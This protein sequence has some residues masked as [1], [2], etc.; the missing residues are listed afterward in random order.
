MKILMLVNRQGGARRCTLAVHS[1]LQTK[2]T[3]V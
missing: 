3:Y 1:L 2:V